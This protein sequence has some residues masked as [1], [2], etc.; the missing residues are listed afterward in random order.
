MGQM[1]NALMILWA[2]RSPAVMPPV[3]SEEGDFSTLWRSCIGYPSQPKLASSLPNKR[4]SYCRLTGCGRNDG[5]LGGQIADYQTSDWNG[6]NSLMK[7][8]ILNKT[9]SW[10]VK[11]GPKLLH[12][13]DYLSKV[14]GNEDILFLKL[15][16]TGSFGNRI[17]LL[18]WLIISMLFLYDF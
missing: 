13:S 6:G 7:C 5:V 4:L 1:E 3:P 12:E 8:E 11:N 9:P 18:E 17:F 16:K 15:W 14:D 2:E 10:N